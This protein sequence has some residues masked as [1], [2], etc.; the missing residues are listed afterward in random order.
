MFLSNIKLQHRQDNVEELSAPLSDVEPE[1]TATAAQNQKH[2]SVAKRSY[3]TVEAAKRNQLIQLVNVERKTIKEAANR[4]KINYSTAKH[5]IKS[6]KIEDA[7]AKAISPADGGCANRAA[8][9]DILK[10]ERKIK[11]LTGSSP[12]LLS[13]NFAGGSSKTFNSSILTT[14][15]SLGQSLS[16]CS[17]LTSSVPSHP[18]SLGVPSS[19][20]LGNHVIN[21]HI[22]QTQPSLV[23]STLAS[24]QGQSGPSSSC[25]KVTTLCY[26]DPTPEAHRSHK[27]SVSL[28]SYFY[29]V[30]DQPTSPVWSPLCA[31][32]HARD[33]QPKNAA[34]VHAPAPI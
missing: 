27:S 13:S 29:F 1:T 4:L 5:I 8:P 19:A 12:S 18:L 22:P 20:T 17:Q 14:S 30:V 31:A 33:Q 24:G 25:E 2:P 21:A 26:R 3:N 16:E 7:P 9:V 28:Y 32:S 10:L 23:S 34:A 15:A 6:K 11:A